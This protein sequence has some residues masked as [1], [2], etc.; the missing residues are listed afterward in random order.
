MALGLETGFGRGRDSQ[1]LV[2][3]Y[4][5]WIVTIVSIFFFY[6]LVG[7]QRAWAIRCY[8]IRFGRA[9]LLQL[10]LVTTTSKALYESTNN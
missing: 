9:Y 5:F 8:W 2:V 6:L 3:L 7:A 4:I 1:G 10:F